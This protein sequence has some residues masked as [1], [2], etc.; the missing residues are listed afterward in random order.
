MLRVT[1]S[2]AI[3]ER[4]LTESFVHSPGPGGQNVNKVATAVELRFDARHS[5][6]LPEDVRARLEQLAGRR[7][8]AEGIIVIRAH[9]F[10]E[11][12]RN[13]QAARERLAELILEATQVPSTRRPT[14]PSRAARAKRIEVKRHKSRVKQTRRIADWE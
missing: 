4:D 10:R 12:E 3:D 13:R 5:R 1:A 9:R 14:R 11:Q 8:N 6:S 2:I 7:M